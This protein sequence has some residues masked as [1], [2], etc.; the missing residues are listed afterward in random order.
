MN[1]S[2]QLSSLLPLVC[3]DSCNLPLWTRVTTN[4]LGEWP[5]ARFLSHPPFHRFYSSDTQ[6]SK[7][8]RTQIT[9]CTSCK[10][11]V[12]INTV[13]T[14]L[15]FCRSSERGMTLADIGGDVITRRLCWK[16]R[17]DKQK[18]T[19]TFFFHG[20]TAPPPHWAGAFS[21]SRLHDHTTTHHPR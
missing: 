13:E 17:R 4:D 19:P 18:R 8:T 6:T 20:A 21:L 1:K 12:R 16:Q 11:E 7:G 3:L 14:S 10:Y 9:L 2:L 15:T 5:H